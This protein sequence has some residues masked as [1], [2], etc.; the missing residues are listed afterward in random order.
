MSQM[1]VALPPGV[2]PGQVI[3]V[4]ALN[5]QVLQVAA[6]VGVPPGGTFIV[7]VPGAPAPQQQPSFIVWK[8]GGPPTGTGMR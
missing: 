1:R 2:R 8:P 7:N 5:G 3:Q 4:R 6:P